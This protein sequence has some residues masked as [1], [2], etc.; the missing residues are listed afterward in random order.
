MPQPAAVGE[1]APAFSLPNQDGQPVSLSDLTA[2]GPVV[3][4]FLS[5]IHI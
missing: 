3:V 4:F 2:L 1:Q 5:L